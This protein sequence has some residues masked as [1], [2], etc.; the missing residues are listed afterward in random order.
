MFALLISMEW[1][2]IASQ[3]GARIFR[4]RPYAH[5]LEL[6]DLLENPKGRL[7]KHDINSDKPGRGFSPTSVSR[8]GYMAS[9]PPDQAAALGFAREIAKKLDQGRTHNSYDHLVLIADPPMLGMVRGALEQ[10]TLHRVLDVLPKNLAWAK[11]HELPVKLRSLFER[12]D[13]ERPLRHV[14]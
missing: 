7:R 6:V 10:Q 9:M 4:R 8:H 12:I 11:P 1:I 13:R 14:G 5:E 3:T 2:V